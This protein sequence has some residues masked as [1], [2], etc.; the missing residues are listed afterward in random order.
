M[1]KKI[2][3]SILSVLLIYLLL[4][5]LL[6][7]VPVSAAVAEGNCGENITWRLEDGTLTIFGA[8]GLNDVPGNFQNPWSAY[9]DQITE[10]IIENGIT[11]IGSGSFYGC[12]NLVRVWMADSVVSIGSYAF[13]S[14]TSLKYLTL[15]K[16]LERIGQDAFFD[17]ESL[18]AVKLPAS[19][20]YLGDGAFYRCYSLTTITVPASV[21]TMGMQVF[22][23]CDGLIRA[24]I[25]APIAELPSGSFYECPSLNGVTLAPETSGV[26]ENAFTN[27]SNLTEL[28]CKNEQAVIDAFTQAA[29]QAN[30][31]FRVPLDT[32]NVDKAPPA[33]KVESSTQNGVT[34]SVITT[35]DETEDVTITTQQTIITGKPGGTQ[36]TVVIS[37]VVE[38]EKGWQD[39]LDRADQVS[40]L[41]QNSGSGQLKVEVILKNEA[42]APEQAIDRLE[43]VADQVTI[44]TNTDT[45]WVINGATSTEIQNSYQFDMSVTPLTE[46]P[47][48]FREFL[49]GSRCYII[50]LGGDS[51]Y[52]V[53]VSLNL[54]KKEVGHVAA[55][56]AMNS[57]GEYALL[58]SAYVASNG[59]VTYYL[60]GMDTDY[61]YYIG[62]DPKNL[63]K[64]SVLYPE[65]DL[66]FETLQHIKPYEQYV[67]T[68]VKSSWGI[69]VGQLTWILIGGFVA[70]IGA[71]GYVMYL[72]NKQRLKKG[73]VPQDLDMSIDEEEAARLAR[74]RQR[75]E[76][77]L[78]P[79]DLTLDEKA[80]ARAE[81][82]NKRKK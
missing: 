51:G 30:P 81:R 67:I 22:A 20:E 33:S 6:P 57:K 60:D 11:S 73:Y 63:E 49:D 25:Q 14:C 47:K 66:H 72:Y 16:N 75:K 62:I 27:C 68:G 46:I 65:D 34:T 53:K 52:R 82:R 12:P 78:P 8:G 44:T 28:F 48:E 15:S 18:N 24:D 1:K 5:T 43:S 29:Q 7:V 61:Q 41:Q 77:P 55:L 42:A 80:V 35:V 37:G 39:V 69:N 56:Y 3:K 79:L 31:E 10:I 76:K 45:K 58:Q 74:K 13:K 26:G 19:L 17:C 50:R 71:V 70:V 40:Q 54:P 38:N 36:S 32:E 2:Q 59:A 9:L 64:D 23:Y 21:Q 4:T